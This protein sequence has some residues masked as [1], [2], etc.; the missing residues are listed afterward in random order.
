MRLVEQ[1]EW[2]E[3][4]GLGGFASGTVTLLRNR[5]YH[6]LLL[7]ATRPP[8]GRMVLVNGLEAW[9]ETPSG[10]YALSS[11]RYAGDVTYPDG[12]N[13]IIA[14]HARPLPLWSFELPDGTCVEYGIVVAPGRS[15][16]LLFWRL[17]RGASAIL[18]VRPLMSG[19]DYH[20]PITK[21]RRSIPSRK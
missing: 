2:I 19:R 15:S 7:I 4:D 5:R 21:T 13:Y 1:D 11:Q 8:A 17:T 14:F 3:A 10:R 9:V 12:T 18:T 16:T 20:S 6:A